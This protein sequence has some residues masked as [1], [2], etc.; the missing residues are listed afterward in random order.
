MTNVNG[1]IFSAEEP[2]A[3]SVCAGRDARANLAEAMG[4][5]EAG[6]RATVLVRG[7]DLPGL[8]D[9]LRDAAQRMLPVVIRAELDQGHAG[10]FA[11]A[12]IGPCILISTPGDLARAHLLARL[13]AEK[14]LVPVVLAFEPEEDASPAL[15]AGGEAT[16]LLGGPA[17]FVPSETPAQRMLFGPNRRRIPR[18]F[19]PERPVMRGQR[20]DAGTFALRLAGEALFSCENIPSLLERAAGMLLEATGWRWEPFSFTNAEKSRALVVG[21]EGSH[22]RRAREV[23]E[24]SS[25]PR[26]GAVALRALRPFPAA[27][28]AA[29]DRPTIVLCGADAA[30]SGEPFLVREIRAARS[31]AEESRASKASPI[32][33]AVAGLAGAPWSAGDLAA[34]AAECAA[35]RGRRRVYLGIEFAPLGGS[36]R[37]RTVL[38]EALR[39]DHPGIENLGLRTASPE[40]ARAEPPAPIRVPVP[41]RQESSHD[42]LARFWDTVVAA[43]VRG[44]AAELAPDPFLTAGS[45]PALS[46]L[47]RGN[48]PQGGLPVFD[49]AKCTGCGACWASCP[50]AA[51]LPLAIDARDL[52]EAGIERVGAAGGSAEALRPILGR[53]AKALQK[54]IESGASTAGAA[55]W[56]AAEALLART[57]EERRAPMQQASDELAK[58]FGGLSLALTEPLFTLAENEQPGG[59]SLLALAIDPDACKGCGLCI[60]VCEPDALRSED[61]AEEAIRAARAAASLWRQLPDTKG[62]VIAAAKQRPEPG[63]LASLELSRHCLWAMAPG[64]DAEPGSGPRIALRTALAVAEAF[65]QPRMR[66]LI[67]ELDELSDRFASGIRDLLSGSLPVADLDALHE[68]LATIGAGAVALSSLAARLDEIASSGRVDTKRLKQLVDQARAL[69]DLRWRL[70]KGTTGQGRARS[71]LVLA[72]GEESDWIP[73]F[74]WNPFQCPATVDAA[75]E[76]G[77]RAAGILR[78]MA[79]ALAR[80]FGEIRSA[81]LMLD[82]PGAPRARLTFAELED[83]ERALLPPLW[84]VADARVLRRGGAAAIEAALESGLPVRILLL[85]AE[86]DE[87]LAARP[88]L[89]AL[90]HLAAFVLQASISCRDHFASGLLAAL[91]HEG[92]ALISVLAPSPKAAGAAPDSALAIASAAVRERAFPLLR[93]DPS[94][95]GAFGQKL[96]LDGNP[97]PMEDGTSDERRLAVWRT[98]QE[99]AGIRSPFTKDIEERAKA[100]VAEERRVEI[101]ALKTEH[102]KAL[103]A[104]RAE[105][106]Q[107]LLG[108]LQRKLAALAGGRGP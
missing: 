87:A 43:R 37:K 99:I 47:F 67:E 56:K 19:D 83:E 42:D 57:D 32:H 39:R 46:S 29:T 77:H 30:L 31:L 53:L 60:A 82:R 107:E 70:E 75:P 36:L 86:L 101:A 50:D 18:W 6:G 100:A 16:A 9:L 55:V 81:R 23:A 85:H 38:H 4:L 72:G 22:A 105:V 66:E 54:A 58:A 1:A 51:V 96:S 41:A 5:A 52:L 7:G 34:F 93:Y 71:G 79:D 10:L 11:I 98:L 2:F 15:P 61:R 17:D 97:D 14:A 12:D 65:L 89:L 63:L 106:E 104:A 20:G 13:T 73:P 94:R 48:H 88:A 44:A 103:A 108:R 26:I 64:D 59:G 35:G 8:A 62:S 78:G 28:L 90:A 25:R 69:A 49:A 21:I 95:E 40:A 74:P 102:E 91:R 33:T 84:L 68:G 80:E 76:A 24:A 3:G 92:P 27:W 45:V